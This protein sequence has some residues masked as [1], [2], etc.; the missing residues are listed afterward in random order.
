M[1]IH[2][3][4]PKL[5]ELTRRK[6]ITWHEVMD[7]IF[8]SRIGERKFQVGQ[9]FDADSEETF[10]RLN[11]Y[12]SGGNAPFEGRFIDSMVADRFK[13]PFS[14]LEELYSEVRR[15]ALGLD[16]VI[17]DIDDELNKLLM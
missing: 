8:V 2:D 5:L 16:K 13:G 6:K 15:N 11:I 17:S 3:L 1:N 9:G 7:N 4:L 10:Y 14:D 12:I